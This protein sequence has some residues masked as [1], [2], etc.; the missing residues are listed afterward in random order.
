MSVEIIAYREVNK[1][2]VVGSV[3]VFLPRNGME[4]YNL[5]YFNKDGKEWISMPSK[6]YEK[7]GQKKYFQ[8][9]RFRDRNH[10]DAFGRAVIEAIRKFQPKPPAPKEQSMFE[11][12]VPF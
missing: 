4:V 9:V 7:D 1:G 5:T 10:Q 8:F 3:D 12:E 6:E 2:S 11:E